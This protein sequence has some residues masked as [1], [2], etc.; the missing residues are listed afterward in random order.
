MTNN[1]IYTELDI[2]KLHELLNIIDSGNKK[3]NCAIILKFG[4]TWCGPCQR[5]KPLCYNLFSKMP[6]NVTCFDIDV[7]DNMDLYLAYKSKKMIPSIPTILGYTQNPTRDKKLWYAPDFS[8]V[9]SQQSQVEQLF[10]S[11]YNKCI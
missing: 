7:D 5:I 4:A 3:D 9:G 8:L 2:T 1:K 11:I 6:E 10:Q